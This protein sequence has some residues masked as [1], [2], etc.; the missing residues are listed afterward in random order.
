[1]DLDYR[2][3]LAKRTGATAR[4]KEGGT[5]LWIFQTT[6]QT[7]TTRKGKAMN[8][9]LKGTVFILAV[10]ASSG[11]REALAADEVQMM[12]ACNTYAAQHLGVSTSNIADLSYQGQRVDGTHAV[13][14]STT[15]GQT[16]QCSFNRSGRRVVGWTHSGGGQSA[17]EFDET[18]MMVTCNTYAARHLGVSTSDIATVKY[19]GQRVDGTHAVNGNTTSGQTFQCSFN[20]SGTHVV[21]WTHSAPA[22]CPV[23]VSE[24]D[25]YLYPDCG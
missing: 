13:N 19:E 12:T 23:D 1:M 20:R 21:N 17:P 25:R 8:S 15:S 24:A 5:T 3:T 9:F 10:V 16:F 2:H 14:G 4:Q 7:L 11:G 22:G 18:Q 6:S